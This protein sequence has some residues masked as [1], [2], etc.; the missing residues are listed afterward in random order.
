MKNLI[1]YKSI[2]VLSIG[3]AGTLF[4][5]SCTEKRTPDTK[6]VAEQQNISKL[7]AEDKAIVVIDNDNDAKFLME[8][9]EMQL[10]EISLGKLAQQKGNTPHVKELG[11]MMHEAHTK[12][13]AELKALALSK[14][15]SIPTSI[16]EDSKDAYEKLEVKTGND[17]GKAYSEMMVEHH[18]DVID[19]FE[20]ASTDSEDAGIRSWASEKLPD[21]RVHLKH[22]E[23]CKVECDKIQS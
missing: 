8:A 17:F 1:N 6:N 10:E 3:I 23:A 11:K 22:A 4:V 14:S 5:A 19:L 2:L 9:A 20:K 7:A 13:L 16:T 18:E 21:L 15:V 12:T